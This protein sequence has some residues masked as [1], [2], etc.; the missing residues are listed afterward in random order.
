MSYM[1]HAQHHFQPPSTD[2]LIE[3]IPF[4]NASNEVLLIIDY[5]GPSFLK[6]AFQRTRSDIA[7]NIST[8]KGKY[9]RDPVKYHTING[10]LEDERV[11]ECSEATVALLWLKRALEFLYHFSL[12]LLKDEGSTTGETDKTKGERKD[13]AN[14]TLRDTSNNER[15]DKEENEEKEY[16]SMSTIT[17]EAY[18]LSL[19]PFHNYLLQGLFYLVAYVLPSK[20]D[21]LK[22]L[23]GNDKSKE[24]EAIEELSEF[25][26]GL[27]PNLKIINK[28][29]IEMGRNEEY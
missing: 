26:K 11:N 14:G 5:L 12:L 4:L 7:G 2:D 20:E 21:F 27:E 9:S 10:L 24:Q 16:I 19:K 3:T 18:E 15:T 29:Y 8:I 13:T 6:S 23:A 25:T 22:L 17:L 28:I 1:F